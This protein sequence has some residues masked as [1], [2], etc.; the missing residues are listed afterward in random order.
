MHGVPFEV[1]L[2]SGNIG[3]YEPLFVDVIQLDC[4]YEGEWKE[5]HSSS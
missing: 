5:G 2:S 1:V 4:D 3:I